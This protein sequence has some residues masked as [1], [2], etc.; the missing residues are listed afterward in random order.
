MWEMDP[1]PSACF[2]IDCLGMAYLLLGMAE[3]GARLVQNGDYQISEIFPILKDVVF[4]GLQ[5]IDKAKF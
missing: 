1:I 5:K 3:Y 2:I 4:N